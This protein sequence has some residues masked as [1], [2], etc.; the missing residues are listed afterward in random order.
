VER[1]RANLLQAMT[2]ESSELQ[3]RVEKLEKDKERL[4]AE[5]AKALSRIDIFSAQ[6]GGG[7]S[8]DGQLRS[9]QS[10]CEALKDDVTNKD[11]Q[12]ILLRSQLEIADRK[13]RLSDM[14]NAMLKSELELRKRSSSQISQ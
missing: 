11:G 4:Q 13:L 9:L 12:I 8:D 5:L 14:E 1:E 7:S 2:D 10:E 6:T 3:G